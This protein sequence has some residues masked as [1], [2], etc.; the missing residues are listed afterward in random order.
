MKRRRVKIT[1]IGPITPAG[2]GREIFSRGIAEPVTRVTGLRIPDATTGTW[3]GACIRDFD[4][5]KYLC[6]FAEEPWPRSTQLAVAAAILAVEDAG[7]TLDEIRRLQPV[8]SCGAAWTDFSNSPRAIDLL[9]K[10]GPMAGLLNSLFGA[11]ATGI[12]QWVG[13]NA[14]LVPLGGALCSGLDA[15]AQGGELIARGDAEVA[16]CGGGEAPLYFHPLHELTAAG[17]APGA[18]DCPEQICRPFDLW[19]TTGVIAEGAC[20]VVLE[21]DQ[22]S[23]RGYAYV[24]GYAHS[25]DRTE[26]AG[27]AWA[28]AMLLALANGKT[29]PLGI[30]MC[31]AYC[32]SFQ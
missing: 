9:T 12:G 27:E 1:G 4:P 17:L 21:P 29:R 11:A 18:I 8:V 30:P 23:R 32:T 3:P 10:P 22:S 14:R 24:D 5:R 16:L 7:L 28:E 20:I 31:P 2:I 19:R 26:Q 6:E 13:E 15:I 25:T